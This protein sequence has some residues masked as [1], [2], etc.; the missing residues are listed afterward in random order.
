MVRQIRKQLQGAML[1]QVRHLRSDVVRGGA[2]GLTE[3]LPGHRVLEVLRRGK[4][5]VLD[6]DKNMR[7]VFG[8]GMTGHVSVVPAEAEVAGH[9][10][11]RVVLEGSRQELRFRDSRRFGG[12]WLLDGADDSAGFARL[13]AD[14]LEMGLRTFRRLLDRPRQIKALLLDQALIAGLGNIYCDE[15]LSRAGIYP[16]ARADQLHPDRVKRLHRAIKQVLEAAI[17]AEGSTINSYLTSRNERGSFQKRL[18][19]YGRH[20]A[21]CRQ[22]GTTIERAQTA[23]RSTHFCPKCQSL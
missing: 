13:G 10:H 17:A 21:D 12:I 22:C 23:G 19:V 9:T 16:P 5:V 6:L 14:P 3:R 4:R 20:G 8:L 18:R 15:A 1:G 7:L 11:L 2:G